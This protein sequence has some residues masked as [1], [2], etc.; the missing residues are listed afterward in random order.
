MA[1]PEVALH[2]APHRE[3]GPRGPRAVRVRCG[4]F[5]YQ[6]AS[7]DRP[8]RVM[9]RS[10]IT[11]A[12]RFLAAISCVGSSCRSPSRVGH[13]EPAT[14][15]VQDPRP[16]HWACPILHPAPGLKPL[17]EDPLS[18]DSRAHR[19]TR[20]ARR[21]IETARRGR[22][23][24]RSALGRSLSRTAGR[25]GQAFGRWAVSLAGVA[26]TAEVTPSERHKGLVARHVVCS[27]TRESEDP[28][29]NRKSRSR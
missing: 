23:E 28:G 9:P 10:S 7:W 4:S 12:N 22:R 20:M 29:P 5:E 16:P 2:L 21:M 26:G 13:D 6:A 15:A 25:P 8:R 18:T 14:A 19:A 11:S 3:P 24:K 17:D 1:Q 27:A